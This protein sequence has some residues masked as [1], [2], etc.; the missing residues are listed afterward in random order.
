VDPFS[1]DVVRAAYDAAASDYEAAFGEDL[2]RL[3]IDRAML[4]SAS[5]VV[6][7]TELVLDLGCGS[8][9]VGSFLAAKGHEVVGLDLSTRM[10]AAGRNLGRDLRFTQGDMRH[11]PFRDNAFPLV[12]AYYSIQHVARD[13][14]DEVVVEVARV[15]T[16]RGVLLLAAHLGDGDVYVDEFLGHPVETIAGAMYRREE[17]LE[18]LRRAGFVLEREQQRGPLPHEFDSQRI[19]LLARLG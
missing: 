12:V 7:S 15:L 19:Y 4:E 18:V 6:R 14:V 3:R 10:M 17:L 2:A 13:E 16:P 8:G 1:S 5:G 9:V 11:V